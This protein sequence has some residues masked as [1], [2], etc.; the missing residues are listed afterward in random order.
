MAV[1]YHRLLTRGLQYPLIGAGQAEI[2]H[3]A[4]SCLDAA[5]TLEDRKRS[6][7]AVPH[8]D[9]MG[10]DEAMAAKVLDAF[11]GDRHRLRRGI[12]VGEL[13]RPACWPL[14]LPFRG[15]PPAHPARTL[16]L[17]MHVG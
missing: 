3:V 11:V 5:N 1:P 8:L 15:R 13:R 7:V 17:D 10:S 14:A 16:D 4:C 6:G 9:R 2:N 12:G